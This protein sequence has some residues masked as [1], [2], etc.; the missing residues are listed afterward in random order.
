MAQRLRSHLVG[1]RPH[2]HLETHLSLVAAVRTWVLKSAGRGEEDPSLPAQVSTIPTFPHAINSLHFGSKRLHARVAHGR[3]EPHSGN[4]PV[5]GA[6]LLWFGVAV[7]A[8][9]LHW[10]HQENGRR[11]CK[12]R[13]NKNGSLKKPCSHNHQNNSWQRI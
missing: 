4:L 5:G 6:V 3:G 11:S 7:W 2:A 13:Q 9:R 12:A 10:R 8:L 1:A